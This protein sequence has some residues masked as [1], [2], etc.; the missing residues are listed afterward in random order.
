[1]THI[2]VQTA[3]TV[4]VGSSAVLAIMFFTVIRYYH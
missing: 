4:A 3:G 1:M 2:I